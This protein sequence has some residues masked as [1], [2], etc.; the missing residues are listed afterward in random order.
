MK[1]LEL[2]QGKPSG[3]LLHFEVIIPKRRDGRQET[4][5]KMKS[6]DL[7]ETK[8]KTKFNSFYQCVDERT[9]SIPCNQYNRK[10][11]PK[12]YLSEKAF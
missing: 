8:A 2:E 4:E 3:T 12:N 11:V 10:L 9:D 5:V 6:L 1:I 7:F